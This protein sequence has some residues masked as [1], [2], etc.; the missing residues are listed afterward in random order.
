[1]VDNLKTQRLN[2]YAIVTGLPR[3]LAE[4][5]PA[6]APRLLARFQDFLPELTAENVEHPISEI[7][8]PQT[9]QKVQSTVGLA[10]VDCGKPETA[11]EFIARA[12]YA[13][14]SRDKKPGEKN[15]RPFRVLSF[16]QFEKCIAGTTKPAPL[17]VAPPPPGPSQSFTWFFTDERLFDQIVFTASN[18]CHAVWFN[19]TTAELEDIPL[20]SYFQHVAEF[21]FSPDGLWLG[22]RD[23]SRLNFYAGERW[24]HCSSFVFDAFGGQS[25]P[26][27]RW[28]FSSDGRY[29]LCKTGRLAF[30]NEQNPSGAAV[31]DLPMGRVDKIVLHKADSAWIDFANGND[32]LKL[33][34]R[35]LIVFPMTPR[36]LGEPVT[37]SPNVDA[38]AASPEHKLVF[39]FRRGADAK[40]PRIAFFVTNSPKPAYSCVAY[41]AVDATPCWHPSL[42]V[43]AVVTHMKAKDQ[44]C[45]ETLTVYDCRRLPPA[46][47]TQTFKRQK[48]ASCAW[49]PSGD[50]LR[51][52]VIL[53]DPR[54]IV[55][56]EISTTIVRTNTFLTIGSR[57][58]FS[59]AGRF[60]V[61]HEVADGGIRLQFFDMREGLI[62]AVE[63]EGV[64][65]V[66]WD[67]SGVFVL[68][69]VQKQGFSI[70]LFDGSLVVRARRPNFGNARWRPRRLDIV[71]Q[72]HIV[73]VEPRVPE[74]VA[75]Y[76]RFGVV[77]PIVRE[78]WNQGRE[79]A[80]S[81]VCSGR[82]A[83]TYAFTVPLVHPPEDMD[84]L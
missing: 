64:E 30:D 60:A 26:N 35:D 79:V 8:H 28:S 21:K 58:A 81:G 13:P 14:L 77:D 27:D 75:Q 40:P 80:P 55:Y 22:A 19:H 54:Q 82:Q 47:H 43:C 68:T 74:A 25:D 16:Q 3:M 41:N 10:F 73:A 4:R 70:W 20:P 31:L 62:R 39:T 48:V 7:E 63:L 1:M 18:L 53:S 50:D 32:I 46:M 72:E 42:P 45:D 23:G 51:L 76:R 84:E 52:A 65:D 83:R 71:D 15:D 24:T 29:L 49:D 6:M 12:D 61:A 66:Q 59:P 37:L 17:E 2:A 78:R 9:H 11:R 67:P 36:G 44:R 5:V 33:S 69:S 34:G 56:F 57:L 38:F